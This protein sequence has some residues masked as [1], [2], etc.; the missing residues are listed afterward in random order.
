MFYT[1]QPGEC[2]ACTC[3]R[4]IANRASRADYYR[5]FDRARG[6]DPKRKEQFAAK[7]RRMRASNPDMVTAHNKLRRAVIRGTIAKGQC[8]ELCGKLP[9]QAHHDDHSHPF[10]VMW[11]C[12]VC[13]AARHR[14]LGRL[15][16][17]A[18]H[19]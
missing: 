8:C 14:E 17:K 9:V 4:V 6:S 15:G 3:A 10:A 2:K 1:Y 18:V 13:H 5:A 11:L 7:Q 16:S 12:P 19:S